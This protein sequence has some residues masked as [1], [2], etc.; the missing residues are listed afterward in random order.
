MKREIS[1]GLTRAQWLAKRLQGITS[2][3]SPALFDLSPY[4][5]LF[6]VYH[7]KKS[8]LL[9]PFESSE[10]MEKGLRMQDAAAN[11]VALRMGWTVRSLE[12]TYIRIP[13]LRLGASFDYEFTKPSGE[14][15]LLE[16]KMVDHF[17]YKGQWS[18]EEI[19]PH[20]EI[21][22]RHQMLCADVYNEIYVAAFTGIYDFHLHH[23]VRDAEFE[24]GLID[25]VKKFW[26]DVEAGNEPKPDFY[27]DNEVIAALYK[28]AGGEAVDKTEDAEFEAEVAKFY[29]LNSERKVIE[30][31]E[32]AQKAKIHFLL[33][34][35]SG[36]FTNTYRVMAGWTKDSA[37]ASITQEMVGTITGGRKGYRQMLVKNIKEVK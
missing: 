22:A 7:A 13:E 17:V 37:G 26:A 21:Q 33:G 29:R 23:F 5:S 20:I 19:P 11:E 3:E 1:E 35:D 4:T 32:A 25:A 34:N 6:E 27:R 15:G 36:A 10:R 12:G 31:D 2:T 9:L 24:A 18:E 28:S 14:K 8:G 30:K 16:I